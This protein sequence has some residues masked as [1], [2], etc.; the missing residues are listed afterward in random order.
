[1]TCNLFKINNIS[2]CFKDWIETEKHFIHTA[3]QGTQEWKDVR[4]NRL[5]ASNSSIVTG[6]NRY[7]TIEN[8]IPEFLG[9]KEPVFDEISLFRMNQGTIHEP[10]AREWY[11]K[12]LGFVVK[13]LGLVVRKEELRLGA[14]TDGVIYETLNGKE[15]ET[16]GI[17]E[18]KCP[19]YM[20]PKL[21]EYSKNANNIENIY[22]KDHIHPEHYEQ[23]QCT[24]WV[25]DK[26]FCDYIVYAI[27][28]GERFIFRVFFNKEYW[29][30][31]YKS[32][33]IFLDTHL[34]Q[35]LN[36]NNNI[37]N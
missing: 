24:M 36:N 16:D 30:N 15:I 22:Y 5:T 4:K 28:T 23:M 31:M 6:K 17:I 13:E 7:K 32:I 3:I 34:N 21:L 18:I 27:K 35:N 10:I 8:Y 37:E 1:M 14:S 19:M 29:D 25:L 33:L 2:Y 20:Y 11:C 12:K 26:K 9:L